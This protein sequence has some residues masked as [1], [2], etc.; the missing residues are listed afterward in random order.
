[1]LRQRFGRRLPSRLRHLRVPEGDAPQAN[2]VYLF[3]RKWRSHRSGWSFPDGEYNE[4]NFPAVQ[5]YN[6]YFSGR[7]WRACLSGTPRARALAYFAGAVYGNGS[8]KGEQN[9]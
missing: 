8:R 1:M 2:R 7:G 3:T 4:A 5:L 9:L 6:E